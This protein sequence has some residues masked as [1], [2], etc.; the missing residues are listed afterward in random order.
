M[1][2]FL[3]V[4]LLTVPSS[5]FAQSNFQKGYVITKTKDTLRGYIDLRERNS[6]PTS[7]T[8]KA[9][10]DAKSQ[11]FGHEDIIAYSI[12]GLESYESHLVNITMSQVD[13]TKITE[14]IDTS[15]RRDMTWLKVLQTGKNVT[16]YSFLDPIKLRFFTKAND[17][18]EP[19]EL[20]RQIYMNDRGDQ[21]ITGET[22]KRQLAALASKYDVNVG[23]KLQN[24]SYEQGSLIKIAALINNDKVV[25]TQLAKSRFFA[26]AGVGFT[27]IYHRGASEFNNPQAS[28]KSNIS[29]N[30]NAGFDTFFNPST[31]K[32]IYRIMLNFNINRAEMSTAGSGATLPAIYRVHTFD[33]FRSSFVNSLIY[34][35]YNKS[36]IKVFLNA[37]VSVNYSIYSNN[38]INTIYTTTK[39]ETSTK[40]EIDL[41]DFTFNYP[42]KLGVVVAKKYELSVGF[43]PPNPLTGYLTHAITEKSYS[44]GFNYL[45]GKH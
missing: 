16:L 17:Q 25:K 41:N 13:L 43:L 44:I 24:L 29:P 26:G 19:M 37:G 1:K 33:Q 3:F 10:V 28:N 8:F 15:F 4:L 39:L 27:E 42:M 45:F 7:V 38:I 5:I 2:Y 36:N 32:I 23:N 6:N 22:Y 11:I 18:K 35:I 14:K 30:I 34:N 40:D 12:D 20:I 9:N 21:M 31:G